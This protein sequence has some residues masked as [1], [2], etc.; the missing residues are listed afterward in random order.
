MATLLDVFNISGRAF[1][2]I[3]VESSRH[4]RRAEWAFSFSGRQDGVD[5]LELANATVADEFARQTEIFPAALLTTG[6]EHALGL[7]Y[8]ANELFTVFNREGEWLLAIDIFAGAHRGERNERMPVINR[9]ANDNV[10]IVA[11]HH[12]SEI[13][14]DLGVRKH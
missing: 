1:P 13:F 14:V 2:Q 10:N 5:V 3:P 9:P 8:R 6:L 7:F 4:W 11:L 12:L